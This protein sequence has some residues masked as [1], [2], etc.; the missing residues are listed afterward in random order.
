MSVA[1]LS[2]YFISYLAKHPFCIEQDCVLSHKLATFDSKN[3][4]KLYLGTQHPTNTFPRI[5]NHCL[6]AK[7]GL[8]DSY[9]KEG[10]TSM[11]CIYYETQGTDTTDRKE[12]PLLRALKPVSNIL[13]DFEI[14]FEKD[15]IILPCGQLLIEVMTSDPELLFNKNK[16]VPRVDT[17]DDKIYS[18]NPYTYSYFKHLHDKQTIPIN[19]DKLDYKTFEDILCVGNSKN[20][21]D[22]ACTSEVDLLLMSN[23]ITPI[24]AESNYI[25]KA[26]VAKLD[27]EKKLHITITA[28]TIVDP[29][30]LA[31][32]TKSP[33]CELKVDD[34][35]V[36]VVCVSS[37][38]FEHFNGIMFGYIQTM[39]HLIIQRLQGLKNYFDESINSIKSASGL[40]IASFCVPSK[41]MKGPY[42]YRGLQPN[43]TWKECI[44]LVS[45]EQ[46]CS[47]QLL[48]IDQSVKLEHFVRLKMNQ[49]E[50]TIRY[51]T[52]TLDESAIKDDSRLSYDFESRTLPVKKFSIYNV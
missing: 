48:I 14:V 28:I 30:E 38:E 12:G 20:S 41:I 36:D 9:N 6:L 52:P 44:G 49:Y 24:A 10:L 42:I 35:L 3:F 26:K 13:S 39:R 4:G 29:V 22:L 47:N 7:F 32:S 46:I 25:K 51:A 21:T 37:K 11:N 17:K 19:N 27:D 33:Y 2:S 40:H 23:L 43:C 45:T 18:L 34:P 8:F 15:T 16:N 31:E 1:S 50:E 5:C